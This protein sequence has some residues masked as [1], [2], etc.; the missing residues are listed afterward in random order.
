M[1]WL[2]SCVVLAVIFAVLTPALATPGRMIFAGCHPLNAQNEGP[3]LFIADPDGYD[4]VRLLGS[5]WIENNPGCIA[6][7]DWSPDGRKLVMR[8][9]CQ[10]AVLDL[11]SLLP[12]WWNY[13][14]GE[15]NPD[16]CCP[17]GQTTNRKPVILQGCGSFPKWSPSGDRIVYYDGNVSI[18]NPDGSGYRSLAPA[19]WDNLTWTVDGSGIV[20]TSDQ[21]RG[22]LYL[23]TD[24]D[25]PSPTVLQLTN[26]A[27]YAEHS[28]AMSPDGAK[29]A[30]S[31]GP[32][33]PPDYEWSV[34]PLPKAGIRVVDYPSMSNLLVLTDDPNFH[35]YVTDFSPDGQYI[36]FSREYVGTPQEKPVFR[37]MWR[38]KAD[39]SAPSEQVPGLADWESL[40]GDL[41]F[42]EKGVYSS[43]T[44]ALPGYT[45]V[46]VKV[47][48]VGAENLAGLQTVLAFRMYSP[49]GDTCCPVVQTVDSCTSGSMITHWTMPDPTVDQALGK[50]RA[51]AYGA[52]PELDRVSGS[53]DLFELRATLAL[54]PL[55]VWTMASA[56]F[57]F[58]SLQ[59]S[60]DWGDPI[61]MTAITG[62]IALK[63]FS[64]LALSSV[65][66]FVMGDESDPEPFSLSIQAR[67]DADEL[68]TWNQDEVILYVEEMTTDEWGR[69]YPVLYNDCVTPTSVVLADGEWTG[70]VTLSKVVE[71]GSRL[72]AKLRDFGG[73]S[74]EFSTVGK[75]DV[76]G[77]GVTNVF[78]VVKIANIAIARGSWTSWQLWAADLNGDVEVNIF[79]VILCARLAMEE[80]S[81]M[82]VGREGA[83]AASASAPSGPITVT[84]TTTST[85]TQ[86]VLS[87][88]LSNCAGVAGVQTELDY[89]AKKLRSPVVSAG[90]VVAGQGGWSVL[91]NDLGGKVKAIAYSPEVTTLPSG[92]GV[93]IK[94][95]FTRIGKGEGKADLVSIKLATANGEEIPSSIGR[96]GGKGRDK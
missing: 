52:N 61:D 88:N 76:S 57:L 13:P 12:H 14:V 18:V 17:F 87:I 58:T 26:T 19:G 4:A 54:D 16:C 31:Y 56:R 28:P 84:T 75:G 8:W 51:L 94:L 74:N 90:P 81:S 60:D 38:V 59:L 64:Y 82:S 6:D 68:L 55:N 46:P 80:M 34:D 72:V 2:S 53:G 43:T 83:G 15:C 24:L 66:P 32:S 62:G 69:T 47:G 40:W 70:D 95:T 30:F 37:N 21:L 44:Y 22:D 93:V 5:D 10:L 23:V 92:Q 77:D 35:D 63:P 7:P 9:G 39:G 71:A 3:G 11:A 65:P 96:S 86:M 29:L 50:V 45:D 41:T 49:L 48:V 1:R 20:Y 67:G 85:N 73:Y 91:G 27:N 89:D 25:A 79:D 78:D 42:L 33:A 36:Y